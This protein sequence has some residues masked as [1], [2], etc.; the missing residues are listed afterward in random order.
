[1]LTS[2]WQ[3][4]APAYLQLVPA[5]RPKA[6]PATITRPE[7]GLYAHNWMRKVGVENNL[8]CYICGETLTQGTVTIEH[9]VPNAGKSHAI[10][11]L[12]CYDC[13]FDK[14]G[15]SWQAFVK[16]HRNIGSRLRRQAESLNTL[17]ANANYKVKNQ[18]NEAG[19]SWPTIYQNMITYAGMA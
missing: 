13:N 11:A 3:L 10:V 2:V 12:A 15:K 18:L 16:T 17:Y 9:L 7:F 4:P 1:M 19:Y 8:D 6:Q 14:G 5:S